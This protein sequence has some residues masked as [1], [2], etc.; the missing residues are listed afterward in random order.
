MAFGNIYSRANKAWKTA[1]ISILP[2]C[3]WKL[4]F[5]FI[6]LF[7]RQFDATL[8]VLSS[9]I[10]LWRYSNAAAVHSAHR[11]YMWVRNNVLSFINV[12]LMRIPCE[13]MKFGLLFTCFKANCCISRCI[14][15]YII[16]SFL[17]LQLS[18]VSLFLL[19]PDLVMRNSLNTHIGPESPIGVW[20]SGD[21]VI[22]KARV[23]RFT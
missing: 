11:E 3:W 20:L 15:I 13:V 23:W 17:L 8:D 21:L 5:F 4:S 16:H 12:W 14:L 6:L 7:L 19:L 2:S 10:V 9:F 1:F 22:V 18:F